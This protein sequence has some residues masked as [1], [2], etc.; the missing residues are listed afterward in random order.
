MKA[1][2]PGALAVPWAFL[3]LLLLAHPVFS[4]QAVD[5]LATGKRAFGDGHYSLAVESF[6][7]LATEF[8]ESAGAEEGEYL[9]GVSLFYAGNWPEALDALTGFRSHHPH[10]AMQSRALYWLA[11]A[12]MK[13]GR[14]ENALGYIR[15]RPSQSEQ[16]DPFRFHALLAAGVA[17]EALGRDEDAAAAYGKI[18]ADAS[19]AAFFPEATFRL[20]GA[21]Y[22]SGRFAAARDLYAR[23]LLKYPKSSFIGDA[24]FFLAECGLALGNLADAE[25]GY[26]SI[27]SLYPDSPTVHTRDAPCVL[28]RTSFLPEKTTPL[29]LTGTRALSR[30]CRKAKSGSR[31]GTPLAS[32]SWHWGRR[33]RLPSHS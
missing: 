28:V 17:C 7:L 26:R 14:F 33:R 22:R 11:A 20:A 21:E 15:E 1:G 18:L 32:R 16:A 9:L 12:S 27:L 19:A 8:P 13:L 3:A 5:L 31:H 30:C 6:R 29:P 2:R 23:L 4:D 24:V 10:S 25:K